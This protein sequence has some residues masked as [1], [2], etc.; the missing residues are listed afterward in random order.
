MKWLVFR[1]CPVIIDVI[2]LNRFKQFNTTQANRAMDDNPY[3]SPSASPNDRRPR[4][5]QRKLPHI[6]TGPFLGTTVGITYVATMVGVWAYHGYPDFFFR[7]PDG[8]I[9]SAIIMGIGGC[10][11]GFL[12]SGALMLYFS[13][14]SRNFRPR[15][16]FYCSTATTIIASVIMCEIEIQRMSLINPAIVILGII[17]ACF[18]IAV[19][20][21]TERP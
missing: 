5:D 21:S 6:L 2:T 18:T 20:T 17:G 13:A 3:H 19:L 14:S 7:G 11:V 4:V 16:H 1:S 12:Y 10:L 9:I 15:L 8:A